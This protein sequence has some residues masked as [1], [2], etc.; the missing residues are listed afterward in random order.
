M[1]APPEDVTETSGTP[2]S[3]ALLAG[4]RE[5]LADDAAHRAA[6]EGE[7]HHRELARH[8]LDRGLADHHRLAEPGLELRLGEPLRCRGAGRR[9][10]AGRRSEGPRPPRR[11]S[12][13]RRAGGS[14]RAPGPG[15]GGRSAGRRSGA[16]RAR[17]RG[18]ASRSS[19]HVFGC[20]RPPGSG[21][22]RFLCSIETS[23]RPAMGS[24]ILD[25]LPRRPVT[26]PSAR[27]QAR[28]RLDVRGVGPRPVT[29]APRTSA[30][31]VTSRRSS[32][33]RATGTP[34]GSGMNTAT[35]SASSPST[36]IAT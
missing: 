29:P 24:V 2:R 30:S 17:R 6:H 23:I 7:V 31:R 32:S 22:G 9:S 14:A 8:V 36:S 28:D 33:A 10:R 13:R 34:S 25:R 16:A 3:A 15:S 11:S 5:L 27:E 12:P 18:S 19:G 35:S 21:S 20:G 4:A 1:R 26:G